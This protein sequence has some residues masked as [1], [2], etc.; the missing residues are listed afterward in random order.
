MMIM[1]ANKKPLVSVPV[2][3]YNSADYIIE[4]LDSIK[5]QTYQNLELIISDDCSMDNTIE[6][7]KR[8][9]EQ[10]KDRFVRYE[11]ITSQVNRGVSANLNRAESSCTGDWVKEVDGDDLLIET[12]IEDCLQYV[13]TYPDRQFIFGR[14]SCFSDLGEEKD[15]FKYFLDDNFFTLS[16]YEQYERLVLKGNCLTSP[17][18]FYNRQAM[19]DIK[20]IND[21]EIPLCEDFPRWI[22]ITKK[23]RKLYLFDKVL[24]K[25]RVR[26]NSISHKKENDPFILSGAKIYLKYCFREQL[27]VHPRQAIFRYLCVKYYISKNEIFR[28]LLFL[29]QVF[30]K[31]DRILFRRKPISKEYKRKYVID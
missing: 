8:W 30:E 21:E 11:I 20:V 4:T 19:L 27:R 18:F 14:I 28:Y 6:L 23:G 2:V 16:A 22:N 15:H 7:C 5:S 17:P 1:E 13:Y 3:T 9:I 26:Q 24:V 25:Y 31:I 29:Y 12:C 10:N